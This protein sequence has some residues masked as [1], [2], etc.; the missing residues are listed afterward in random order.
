M[1]LYDKLSQ[2][3]VDARKSRDEFRLS[4]IQVALSAVKNERI[5]KGGELT[6]EEVQSVVGK[7]V[8]QLRDALKDFESAD[9]DDLSEKTKK[10]IALLEN[11][12]PVRMSD[13]EV[14]KVI[15]GAV[16]GMTLTGSP[17]DV[18]K[19]MGKVMSEVKG[20]I[21]GGKVKEL[22]AKYMANLPK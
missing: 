9:R 16:S 12:L 6:D 13:D 3:M 5:N 7:Q 21:D 22:V 4:I 11:Y 10:E 1:T 15:A 19:I 8:K 20:K 14:G 17:G 18:G 2:D